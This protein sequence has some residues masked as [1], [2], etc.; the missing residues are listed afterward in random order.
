MPPEQ[1]ETGPV[2]EAPRRVQLGRLVLEVRDLHLLSHRFAMLCA[3]NGILAGD[4]VTNAREI[5]Q[6][7][8]DMS[9]SWSRLRNCEAHLLRGYDTALIKIMTGAFSR[10]TEN[11]FSCFEAMARNISEKLM[12]GA[13]PEPLELKELVRFVT[14]ELFYCINDLLSAASLVAE[15][16]DRSVAKLALL[17]E[18]TGLPN[19]RALHDFLHRA[20]LKGWPED[21]VAIM[22]VDLDSFKKVN[23]TLGHGAGDAALRFG[24]SAMSAFVRQGD[25]LARV[26]GDEFVLMFFGDL[27]DDWLAQVAG[28][29]ITA[30]SKPF[31]HDGKEVHISASVGIATGAKSDHTTLDRFMNNADLALYT[32][33]NAGRGCYRFFSPQLRK[34]HDEIE[35]LQALIIEGMQDGQFE[36]FFQPQVEGR[37]G[38]V[39]GFE[40]L[41]RWHHPTRGLLT[42]F[43]FLEAAEAGHLLDQLDKHLM[44]RTFETMR[45]WVAMGLTIPQ[46][47]INLTASRLLEVDLV[48]TI[49]FAAEKFGVA[50]HSVGVEILESAMIDNSSQRMIENIRNLSDAGFKVELDDFGTGHAS[51]SNLRHFKV[52]RIKIDRSFVKDVHLYSDL[53]RIT[54]AMI[55]LAHSLRV[56]ALAEGVESPEERLV[57]NALG[58]DFIQGFGVAR[59]M[60][61]ANIPAWMAKAKPDCR[62][63]DRRAETKPV[64][65]QKAA[66]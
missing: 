17:D 41:A 32:A 4:P 24:A 48:D 43:H 54:S 21:G 30:I 37:S 44:E 35:A 14:H 57:L 49:S 38:K 20:E 8:R 51:I 25:F 55:G 12:E 50:P 63:P 39:V 46:V 52:D 65:P 16:G 7:L 9:A 42:P 5:R 59:P 34:Q 6:V 64:A 47:S 3:A 26:G 28:Q 22:H 31:A 13:E 58:C 60:P 36:P 62:L 29:M 23:D 53:A 27:S 18:L 45:D 2:F 66:D 56:D 61:A 15:M 10:E 40:A 11:T 19:R 1:T 33:K